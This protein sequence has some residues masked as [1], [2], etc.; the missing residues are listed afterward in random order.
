SVGKRISFSLQQ[1][2]AGSVLPIGLLCVILGTAYAYWSAEEAVRATVRTNFRELARQGADKVSLILTKEIQWV[3]R[4]SASPEVQEAVAGGARLKLDPKAFHQWQK[5]QQ[6]YFR[7]LVIVDREGRLVGTAPSES[8]REFYTHQDWW[9]TTVMDGHPWTGDFHV[10]DLGRGYWEVAVPIVTKNQAVQ[11]ALKVAIATDDLFASTLR[12]RIGRTGH[13]MLFGQDGRILACPIRSPSHHTKLIV[14]ARDPGQSSLLGLGAV[15]AEVQDDGHRGQGAIVGMAPVN[16]PD[17]IVQ[18]RI[19]GTLVRQDPDEMT[20]PLRALVW[21]LLGFG[22]VALGLVVYLRVRLAR[23]IVGPLQALI[24]RLKSLGEGSTPVRL[25]AEV[26]K[27]R[28][29]IS[30]ITSLTASFNRLVERLQAAAEDTRRYVDELERSGEHYRM[31]WNHSADA[32]LIVDEAAIIRDVN[33]RAEIKLSRQAAELVGIGAAGLFHESDQPR[34]DALF[35]EVRESG[36]EGMR[37]DMR[38]PTPGGATLVMELDMVPV[39]IKGESRSFLLQLS[40]STERKQ[41]EAQLLRSERLAS[42]SQFASMFAHDIRNPLAGIKKT[43]ELVALRTGIYDKESAQ[44]MADLQ[45][46]TE[47]LL[48]MINDTLD[49]YQE[50][51]SGLPLVSSEFSIQVL[52]EEIVSL[53][54]PEADAKGV[55]FRLDPSAKDVVITGDRRR[56]QRVGINLVHNA[57]KYSPA[58]GRVTIR[59]RQEGG[60]G[61]QKPEAGVLSLQVHDEG[62]GL[63]PLDLPHLFEMFF[64]KKDSHDLRIGRGLGLHFCKLVV[65]AHG[66]R[67]WADN[68]A[69]GGAVFTLALP[70]DQTA[71]S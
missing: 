41:L 2:I 49:V 60:L 31:L 70:L 42:L 12:V 20:E 36:K 15:W 63:D 24:T 19:W 61:P 45:V 5:E 47:L 1:A 3:E 68:R 55:H 43:L 30:E 23:R 67:I 54:R 14:S 40:D 34:L 17:G 38:V 29:E 33:R 4:L 21:K 26:S 52:L 51:Y 10:D 50:S 27:H 25:D 6:R 13:V 7:S 16:L 48:G 53:L 22:V 39:E 11:G 59:A 44:L 37:G 18:E 69:E 35:S 32:K 66:G 28:V 46:A 58:G 57:L 64:R 56:L 71:S 9:R 65:E 62:P 8:Q